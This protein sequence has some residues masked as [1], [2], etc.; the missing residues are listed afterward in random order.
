MAILGGIFEKNKIADKIKTYNDKILEEKFWK[1]KQSAQKILK[2]KKFF[3]TISDNFYYTITELE[4]FRNS[5]TDRYTGEKIKIT[6]LVFI[7]K[8]LVICLKKVHPTLLNKFF[9]EL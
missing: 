6:P 4:N 2:E 3:E 8:A 9:H 7:M 1:D 5:L